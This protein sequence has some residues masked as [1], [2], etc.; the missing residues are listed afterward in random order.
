ML[1]YGLNAPLDDPIH[2]RSSLLLPLV[3]ESKITKMINFFD[4]KVD[5]NALC[6][7]FQP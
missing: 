2:R 1:P 4:V 7:F 6:A 3:D 5:I